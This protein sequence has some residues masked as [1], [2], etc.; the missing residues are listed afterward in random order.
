MDE[1]TS[2]WVELAEFPGCISGLISLIDGKLPPTPDMKIVFAAL[3]GL[4]NLS[5]V[6][7][8]GYPEEPADAYTLATIHAA[9]SALAS[10]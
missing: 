3:A 2:D 5:A 8:V 4:R 1:L 6:A 7:F 10:L 9:K